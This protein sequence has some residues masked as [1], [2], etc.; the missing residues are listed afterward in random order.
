MLT[1][2]RM[3]LQLTPLLD[4]LL[5]IVFAQYLEMRE[6]EHRITQKAAVTVTELA[7]AKARLL[8]LLLK[9][10]ALHQEI[11]VSRALRT[12]TQ[13]ALTQ[14]Q[15]QAMQFQ[16]ELE[17]TVERQKVVSDMISEMF[18]I[19]EQEVDRLLE[20]TRMPA[21][22]RSPQE[23]SRLKDQFRQFSQ[24]SSGRVVEH[25]LSYEEIRKRCD[26]W[27][28]HV[29]ASGFISISSGPKK[30][31]IQIPMLANEDVDSEALVAELYAWYKTLPEP[32]SLVVILMTYDRS[33]RIAMTESIRRA[34][35]VLVTRMQNDHFGSVRFEY[36]DLGFRL[37]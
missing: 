20:S 15:Q 27:E 1:P 26:V 3:A 9:E 21:L 4:M 5:I 35:P 23:L 19:P 33:S 14:Q 8:E 17:L 30:S 36:A 24:K 12:E 16:R 31:R 28:L 11:E 7:D 10:E 37:D 29:D 25:L 13:L 22:E 18:Q 32:K 2:R 34:L 6:T